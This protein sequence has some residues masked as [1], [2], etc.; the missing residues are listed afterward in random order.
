MYT[1]EG[2]KL[3]NVGEEGSSWVWCCDVDPTGKFVVRIIC[4]Q[5]YS[6]HLTMS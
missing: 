4:D 6:L 1:K 3:G 2:I 5:F